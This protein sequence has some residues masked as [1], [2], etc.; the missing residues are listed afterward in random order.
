MR[1]I[2]V[3]SDEAR[4]IAA[5]FK[6]TNKKDLKQKGI[7]IGIDPVNPLKYDIAFLDLDI[8]DWQKRLLELRQ[9]MPVIAFS[10]SDVK[11]AVEAMKLGATDFLEKPITHEAFT[12]VINRHKKKNT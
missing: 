9:R 5:L 3:I 1:N 4:G 2:L 8:D 6:S 10:K 7:S 12:A 11:K